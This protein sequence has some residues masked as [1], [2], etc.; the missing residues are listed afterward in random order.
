MKLSTLLAQNPIIIHSLSQRRMNWRMISALALTGLIYCPSCMIFGVSGFARSGYLS[1]AD[2]TET[3]FYVT[4]MLLLITVT[5][6]AP[7]M[8]ASG[9]AGEKQRQTLDLLLVTLLPVRSLVLGKLIAALIYTLILIAA[10]W[11][12]I[13]FC[14]IT[15]G[16]GL[17]QLAVAALML[18]TTAI[19]FTTIGLYVSSLS[20]TITNAVMLSYGVVLPGLFIAPVLG[21]IVISII[22]NF[23]DASYQ[24]EQVIN[25]YGW[26]LAL[27]FNP[28]GAAIYSASAYQA[29][30]SIFLTNIAFSSE[31][32]YLLSPWLIFVIFYSV[33]TLVLV[34][35]TTKRL[36][37]IAR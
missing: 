14:L 37:R 6:F 16:V 26:A 20:K 15:G 13:L 24:L 29:D 2:V 35:L 36:E 28:L 19:A 23:A 3:I 31:A 30:N 21:M 22:L 1:L 18:M 12:I 32:Y 8:S 7:T 11:P 4:M 33:A 27:S 5:L 34:Q 10:A 17:I 9:I 25:L